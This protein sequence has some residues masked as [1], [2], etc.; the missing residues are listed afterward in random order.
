MPRKRDIGVRALV[1][2]NVGSC[3]R[4]V[5]TRISRIG[6]AVPADGFRLPRYDSDSGLVDGVCRGLLTHEMTRP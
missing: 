1:V 4:Q 5:P 3:T 6:G 2:A